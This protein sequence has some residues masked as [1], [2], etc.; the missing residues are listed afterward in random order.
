[1][2]SAAIILSGCGSHSCNF[3]SRLMNEPSCKTF[4]LSAQRLPNGGG[5]D[6]TGAAFSRKVRMNCPTGSGTH[7]QCT[8]IQNGGTFFA[9]LVPNNAGGAFLDSTGT[10]YTNCGALWGDFF[11]GNVQLV[12]GFYGSTTSPGDVISCDNTTG[13]TLNPS[14]SCFSGWTAGVG[15]TGTASLPNGTSL[16]ACAY[17]DNSFQSNPPAPPAVGNWSNGPLVSLT[18]S[19]DPTFTSG[20]GDA[21]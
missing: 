20:W 1:M 10:L 16:L 12:T 13:C 18:I 19:G 5:A 2:I 9:L 14:L 7:G 3:F 17:I 4:T 6:C 8:A 15:I 11:S 21:F